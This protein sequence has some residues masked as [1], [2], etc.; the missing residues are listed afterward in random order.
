VDNPATHLELT[1]VHKAMVLEY[2]GP[3]LA[4]MEVAAMVKLAVFALLLG[5]LLVPAGL[6]ASS[7]GPGALALA[8]VAACLKLAGVM[9]ALGLAESS[10]AKL[11]FYG[12]PEY[13]FA[14][15]FLGLA[16]LALGLFAGWL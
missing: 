1:M 13:F 11:R 7:S 16:S 2:S 14:S 4:V 10:M 6:L 3:Y 15:L 9:A 12:L 5:N 8:P